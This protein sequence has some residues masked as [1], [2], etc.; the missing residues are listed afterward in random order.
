[1]REDARDSQDQA[2]DEA[3]AGSPADAGGLAPVAAGGEEEAHPHVEA[4]A[5]SDVVHDDSDLD[6]SDALDDESAAADE[7]KRRRAQHVRRK[8]RPPDQE[9]DPKRWIGQRLGR[10]RIM[11]WL[12]DG[13]MGFVYQAED[14][15]L[16]R[17]AALK[18]L[19][20]DVPGFTKRQ[21]ADSFIR[22]ARAAASLHH[23][24]VVS[25]YEVDRHE[26]YWYLAMEYVDGGSLSEHVRTSGPMDLRHALLW[27][28]DIGEALA[29]TH[30]AGI[31]HRD[32]KPSNMLV[33]RLG[34]C[35]LCDFGLVRIESV[36]ERFVLDTR[37]VGTPFYISPETMSKRESSPA[38]D[39]YSLAASLYFTIAG[40][41]PF[42]GETREELFDKHL[43][44]QP[45][46]LREHQPACSE[47]LWRLI[48]EGL[49]K[50]PGERPTALNFAL[51]LRGELGVLS[52]SATAHALHATESWAGPA[53][54]IVSS[55][56]K[57]GTGGEPRGSVDEPEPATPERG[58]GEANRWLTAA[59]I[60]I[61]V[62]ALIVAASTLPSWT[63]VAPIRG[64]VPE[65]GD[66]QRGAVEGE[67]PPGEAPGGM[68]EVDQIVASLVSAPP[69][70]RD[71]AASLLR[72]HRRAVQRHEGGEPGADAAI[73]DVRG[74][75][76]SLLGEVERHRAAAERI[77]QVRRELA[78]VIRLGGAYWD[79]PLHDRAR[80]RLV[81]AGRLLD[82]GDSEGAAARAA[83]A[84][85]AVSDLMTI[86]ERW[87]KVDQLRREFNELDA[88][89][90]EE[91]Y[92]DA[93]LAGSA[94][95][96]F[97]ALQMTRRVLAG[98][99]PD[100]DRSAELYR[101]AIRL[102]RGAVREAARARARGPVDFRAT[103]D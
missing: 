103:I 40:Q 54:A 88:S 24:G 79:G 36:N 74:R 18:I 32:V 58:G 52:Q 59:A 81:E 20:K 91:G 83:D 27:G 9:S 94:G 55:E 21:K 23:P 93:L 72:L 4:E 87:R 25:V 66:R 98:S 73:A 56:T 8:R 39:V 50:S 65:A 99:P 82:R 34:R 33:T 7:R 70:F 67:R 84:H 37:A 29:A 28:A 14:V 47:S 76:E 95:P 35:K 100:P 1:L 101:D 48:A 61:A 49:S 97:D 44:A 63:G 3:G 77:D 62:A 71:E 53:A 6:G 64:D 16:R 43:H 31:V 45:V 5:G 11:R 85:V 10:F 38:S 80:R 26:G 102:L 60:V 78:E 22:E 57:P 17:I 30:E 42:N 75:A 68:G 2:I 92:S 90:L 41:P 86:T 46:D 12:G 13:E 15:H 96:V 89:R 51:R 69:V 19:R